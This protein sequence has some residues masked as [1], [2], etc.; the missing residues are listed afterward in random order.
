MNVLICSYLEPELVEQIQSQFPQLTVH[1]QPEL[2]PKPRYKADHVGAPFKRSTEEQTRWDALLQNADILFDFDYSDLAGFKEKAR[3][4]RWLQASSAGIG[5]LVKRQ[6]FD[7][8]KMMFTTASGVHAR[9]LAEFVLMVMLEHVKC[10]AL[11]RQ[12][13]AQHLWQR[14]ATGELADKTLAIVGYGNI[15]KEVARLAKAFDMRV[16]ANKRHTEGLSA[17]DL[18]LH[19]LFAWQDLPEMLGQADYICIITPHTPETE[20]LFNEATF[21]AVKPGAVLI[22]I[23][24]GIIVDEEALVKALDQ[25][26]LAHAALDVAATEPLP[27]ESKLWSHPKI[28]IFPHSAST[29]DKENERLVALFCE[30]LSRYLKQEP[31]LNQLDTVKMY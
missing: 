30:N 31:L 24:R 1:Y 6:G 25:G 10:A 26:Q 29:S 22:N 21:A 18:G 16:I 20:H 5:Q 4:A 9:P 19:D 15:G 7:D 2:L 23:A 11:A 8:M 28:T 14:F 27:P 17:R 12:Q 13:Q 3:K